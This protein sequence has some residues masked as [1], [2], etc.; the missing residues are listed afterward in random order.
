MKLVQTF[1]DEMVLEQ[2]KSDSSLFRLMQDDR[3]VLITVVHV[4]DMIVAAETKY[5]CDW[6]YAELKK[7]FPSTDLGDLSWYL[8]CA[9]E[10]NLDKGTLRMSQSA[11]ID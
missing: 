7:M 6:L 1:T 10:R 5:L 8:R 4:H 3:V 2:S 9:F 11:F